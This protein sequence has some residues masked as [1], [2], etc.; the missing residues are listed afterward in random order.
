MN[1]LLPVLPALQE[2]KLLPQSTA[3]PSHDGAL[4]AWISVAVLL[5]LLVI[6]V[7]IVRSVVVPIRQFMATTD[8]LAKGDEAARLARGSIKELDALALCSNR[9]AESLAEARE[10]NREYQNVLESRVDERTRQLQHLAEHDPLTGLPQ[11]Q[12]HQR[13]HGTQLWGPGAEK[14]GATLARGGGAS[15]RWESRSLRGCFAGGPRRA[16]TSPRVTSCRWRKSQASSATSLI[17][18]CGRV[19]RMARRE[20]RGGMQIALVRSVVGW[21]HRGVP[22]ESVSG[23]GQKVRQSG[24]CEQGRQT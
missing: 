2:T 7:T 19:W 15:R 14:C 10:I 3:A 1:E 12:E 18:C 11:L 22:T 4:L 6:S 8:R 21:T 23:F 17:G 9:M 16:N 5:I 20:F 13:Q 24:K